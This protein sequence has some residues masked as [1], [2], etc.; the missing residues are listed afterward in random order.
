MHNYSHI[1]E[2][3][4]PDIMNLGFELSRTFRGFS[5]WLPLQLIGF[6]KQNIQT[7]HST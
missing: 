5:V 1:P 7:E 3:M 4:P 2:E 6:N